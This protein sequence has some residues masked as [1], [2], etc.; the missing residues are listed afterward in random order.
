MHNHLNIGVLISVLVVPFY[1]AGLALGQPNVLF[2]A[3][4][5][6]RWVTALSTQIDRIK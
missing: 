6:L 3:I 1:Q 2:I 4:D 5:D